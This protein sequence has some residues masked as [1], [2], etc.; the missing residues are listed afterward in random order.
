MEL[1]K[2]NE[3]AVALDQQESLYITNL[4]ERYEDVSHELETLKAGLLKWME[5]N[6]LKKVENDYLIVTYIAE[7][8]RETFDSKTFRKEHEELYNDYIK[9]STTQPSVRIKLK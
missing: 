1:I 4:L 5:T 2:L 6:D 7:T 9:L 3:N 8:Y